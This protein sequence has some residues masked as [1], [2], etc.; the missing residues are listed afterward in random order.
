MS[1]KI[2]DSSDHFTNIELG[3]I[4]TKNNKAPVGMGLG[5]ASLGD[6]YKI[7]R[8]DPNLASYWNE[9]QDTKDMME[10]LDNMVMPISPSNPHLHLY[11]SK[12][13]KMDGDIA[14]NSL[15]TL[16]F[17]VDRKWQQHPTDSGQYSANQSK[18]HQQK[19][20]Q[21]SGTTGPKGESPLYVT[22]E[23]E[24]DYFR[25]RKTYWRHFVFT[26]VAFVVCL[27]I[28]VGMGIGIGVIQQ[29]RSRLDAVILT[30]PTTIPTITKTITSTPTT[31]LPPLPAV[32][33][34]T[35]AISTTIPPPQTITKQVTMVSTVMSTT[36]FFP[37]R[38]FIHD[39]VCDGQTFRAT[40]SYSGSPFDGHTMTVPLPRGTG[41]F[42]G[43]FMTA[44]VPRT[45]THA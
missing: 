37:E 15:P 4:R 12:N 36:T 33:L 1:P 32:H 27:L 11:D 7:D 6:N 22:N 19:E 38:V 2:Q 16:P 14:S 23:A 21:T 20:N 35:T 34:T 31:T 42:E 3:S 5:M 43:D 24:I 13:E 45:T 28:I 26:L 30:S 18:A 25:P 44:Y 40:L 39:N 29:K 9:E 41:M 17:P 10:T 8:G